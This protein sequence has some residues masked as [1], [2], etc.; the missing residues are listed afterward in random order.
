MM[1]GLVA[2]MRSLW[3]GLRRRSDEDAEL[4]EEFRVHVELRAQDLVRTGLSAADAVRQARR[5]FGDPARYGDEA[6]ASRGLHY[7]DAFRFSWLDFKLG[8]RMLARYPGLTVVGG[9]A[10][11]FAVWIGA[12]TFELIGQWTHPRLPLADGDR[13]VG[14]QLR[15]TATRRVEA[16][17]LHDFVTWRR[18]LESVE[19]LSAF[20]T[21]QRN[22][23][24]VEGRGEP[25][26]VA[27]ISASA[28]RVA[29][30]RPQLGRFLVESDELA[31]APPV[32]VLGHDVW[33]THFGG[34]RAVIGR[35]VRLGS[36]RATVVGVMPKEFA[37]PIAHE[38]W[39]PL[40]LN[41]P[42]Y[43]RLGGP[44]IR[45]LG[46]LADGV[47]LDEAQS[48][49]EYLGARAAADFP[50][51]HEHLRPRVMPLTRAILSEFVSQSELAALRLVNLFVVMLIVLVCGNVAL[52]MLA[53][54]ATR[55]SEI[56]VRSAL[57]ASRVRIVTQLLAEAL[58]LG[59]VGA[60]I[61]LAA[62]GHG[63]GWAMLVLEGNLGRL[64]FWIHDDV[65]GTTLLYAG[66][67][68]VFA[69]VIAGVLPALRVTRGLGSRLRQ[70]TAGG[71][72]L[73]FSGV[74]TVVIVAQ[75]AVTVAFPAATFFLRRTAGPIRSFDPGF[76]AERFLSVR[77][78]LAGDDESGA[79][80]GESLPDFLA[81]FHRTYQELERRLSAEPGVEAVTFASRLPRML[82][83]D[84]RIDMVEGVSLPLDS[85]GGQNVYAATVDGDYFEV[86]DAP[87]LSG[88][89]FN[90]ADLEPDSRVVI[91]NQSFV[92]RVLNGRNAIGRRIRF[93]N[94]RQGA[95]S[96]D[97]P[98]PWYEIVGVA[99]D[100]GM[101]YLGHTSGNGGAGLYQPLPTG[102]AHPLYMAARLQGDPAS[103]A[104]RLQHIAHAVDPTLRLVDL[105]PLDE[106]H[107]GVL[108]MISIY[109]QIALLMSSIALL[110]SLA[111]IYSVM[112][113]A[114]SRRTRE[115]GVRVA[116]GAD[117]KRVMLAVFSRPLAQVA[118]GIVLGG[119][120][121][122]Q[123][124]RSV[125]GS[126][127][128]REIGLVIAYA[129]LM[130]AVCML[131]CIV[132]TRRALAVQPTEALGADG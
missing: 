63:L 132:P 74:W 34:D 119:W 107:H 14:I 31:S 77:L 2:R 83:G 67:L 71:G 24:T 124:S 75:V 7:I 98:G 129:T 96:S 10:M 90:A 54:A 64:P 87:L 21:L 105:Q 108:A 41:V 82:H 25:V 3:R 81:R 23:F 12:G 16:R 51:T 99:R 6:R 17:S 113:F 15:H 95:A 39:T 53:R 89:S 78:E 30:V 116:L 131:A 62:T 20:R 42:S 128:V 76:A 32:I 130:M 127:S 55:E 104:P 103:F 19:D 93:T 37:Y 110:L 70:V 72:G 111:G 85:V 46:R 117:A 91:V 28:F 11:A 48:E 49:L 66:G 33:R 13:I 58:V 9:L 56:V 80:T 27:E 123:L 1:A 122:A 79:P 101:N 4:D 94:P 45:V 73:K 22:L 5:E 36:T 50:A 121:V 125:I 44:E 65:S 38:V 61:G 59:G 106:V 109:V 114:V 35:T 118:V 69:A 115:I 88:R 40:R 86:L 60:I 43:P 100:L 57:G 102:R 8:F 97:E 68:T 84:L 52:L 92:D 47:T 126:L 120:L 26:E 29:R 112:S 18:E